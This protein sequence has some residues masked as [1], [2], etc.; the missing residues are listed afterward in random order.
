MATRRTVQDPSCV[1]G[2]SRGTSTIAFD[3]R[4]AAVCYR[5]RR[6]E[7]HERHKWYERR[8]RYERHQ[9]HE[10]CERHERCWSDRCDGCHGC[11]G[12]TGATGPAGAGA[13]VLNA[14][15][16][17]QAG[18]H[19]VSGTGTTAGGNPKTLTVTLTGSAVLTSAS[20]YSCMVNNSTG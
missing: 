6:H 14:S 10:R 12:A 5:P 11:D 4:S 19:W 2:S 13:T 15:G 8:R 7:R 16:T 1:C 20:S 18:Y 3:H 9:W 17:P